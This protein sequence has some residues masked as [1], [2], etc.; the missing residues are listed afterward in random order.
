MTIRSMMSHAAVLAFVASL[1]LAPAAIAADNS[2]KVK[3][4]AS[5]TLQLKANTSTK[6]DVHCST[7]P[8]QTLQPCTGDFKAWCELVGGTYGETANS[9]VNACFHRNE[10]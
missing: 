3:T 1:T 8:S 6:P 5:P 7:V 4:P 2:A 10:W 9:D